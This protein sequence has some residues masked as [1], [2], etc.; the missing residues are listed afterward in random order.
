ML[1]KLGYRVDLAENGE[2]A[3]SA[4]KQKTYDVVLMD[5]QMPVLDGYEAT[6]RIRQHPE[7]ASLPIIAVTANVMQ[8]DKDDCLTA[9]MNDYITKP[10]NKHELQAMIEHW[11]AA[12]D[13]SQEN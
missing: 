5:C 12:G 13:P 2:R 7:W 10:Y 3:I 8:G 9:G 1:R 11:A 4:L 6:Q